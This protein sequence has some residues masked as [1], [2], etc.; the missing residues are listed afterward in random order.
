MLLTPFWRVDAKFCFRV[1][2]DSRNSLFTRTRNA[3]NSDQLVLKNRETPGQ[4]SGD[5]WQLVNEHL[6]GIRQQ[7][8]E[9]LR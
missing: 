6:R 7:K 5:V 3:R 1:R 9:H 8:I 2:A 4:H